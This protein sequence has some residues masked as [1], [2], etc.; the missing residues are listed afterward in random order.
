MQGIS[1]IVNDAERGIGFVTNLPADVLILVGG[2]VALALYGVRLGKYRLVA[3]ILSLFPAAILTP[4]VAPYLD[5][6]VS[7]DL[8]RSVVFLGLALLIHIGLSHIVCC[9]F[10]G[11][12]GAFAEGA[13]FGALAV[14]TLLSLGFAVGAIDGVHVFSDAVR[15]YATGFYSLMWIAGS[16]AATII[17][18]RRF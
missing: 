18:A 14:G 10:S 6:V 9:E 2:T 13:L 3:L 12:V 5:Q 17:T 1:T 16:I 8:A 4:L 7:P 11:G 15:G